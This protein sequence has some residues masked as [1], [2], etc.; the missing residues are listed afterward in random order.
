MKIHGEPLVPRPRSLLEAVEGSLEETHMVVVSRVNKARR[1]LTVDGLLQVAVK[2]SVLHIQLVD[3]PA[4]GS[5]DAEDDANRR[6]LDDRVEGLIVV[7]AV[8]LSEAVNNP[9]SLVTGK[10]T[11]GVEFMIIN[12][13]ASHN[14]RA[15]WSR[16]ETLGVVVDEGLVLVRHGGTP[17]R[18]GECTPVVPRYWETAVETSVT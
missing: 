13:L 18:V 7:D 12:P 15:R 9:A 1:L 5:G 17:L 2:K 11:V 4:T 14:V 3:Q 16:D 10:G 6:R 8:A